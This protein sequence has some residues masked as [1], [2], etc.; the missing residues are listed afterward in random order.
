MTTQDLKQLEATIALN[1]PGFA[2][3]EKQ[4]D[5]KQQLLGFLM[6]P[7]NPHYDKFIST[8]SPHVYWQS[9]AAYHKSPIASMVTLAHEFVHLWDQKHD[10]FFKF[11]YML[12]QALALPLLL[13]YG[14]VSGC[15]PVVVTLLAGLLSGY[16]AMAV[17]KRPMMFWTMV[18]TMTM[19]GVV[20]SALWVKL[21]TLWLVA[22]LLCL[23][24]LPAYWRFKYELR[25]YVMS[26]AMIHWL[27][28]EGVTPA[29]IKA[30]TKYFTGPDY[31]FMMPFEAYVHGRL[32]HYVARIQK[33]NLAAAQDRPFEIMRAHL[34]FHRKLAR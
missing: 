4:S 8:F 18:G 17:V 31:Y 7:F 16:A 23:G 14:L 3:K 1:I 28:P 21:D 9:F 19:I 22:A 34:A 12:P 13:V 32:E 2:V 5:K 24:P 29:T 10:V 15:W 30:F 27:T 6:Q 33:G 26:L 20:L 25:G 11:K